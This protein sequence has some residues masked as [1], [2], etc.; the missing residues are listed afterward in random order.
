[1]TVCVTDMQTIKNPAII[2]HEY[3]DAMLTKKCL[4]HVESLVYTVHYRF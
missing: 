1:M 4:F 3:H 2:G